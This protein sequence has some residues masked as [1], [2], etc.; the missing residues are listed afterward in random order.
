M[1]PGLGADKHF[2]HPALAARTKA[3]EGREGERAGIAL[4]MGPKGSGRIRSRRRQQCGYFYHPM[5]ALLGQEICPSKTT[6]AVALNHTSATRV[7][8]RCDVKRARTCVRGAME[9]GVAGGV[10]GRDGMRG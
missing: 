6:G 5:Q 9:T 1:P 8:R 10:W 4:W 2:V 3:W 7:L